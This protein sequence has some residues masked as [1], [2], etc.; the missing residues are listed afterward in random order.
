M[1]GRE[2]I[3][4]FRVLLANQKRSPEVEEIRP[5]PPEGRSGEHRPG[6]E[7][8]RVPESGLPKETGAGNPMSAKISVNIFKLILNVKL[9]FKKDKETN[10][11]LNLTALA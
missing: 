11:T 9:L 10:D 3:L 4:H 8:I 7:G 2:Q 6:P 1:D 5:F